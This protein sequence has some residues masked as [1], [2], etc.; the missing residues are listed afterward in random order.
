MC[1][2]SC[3]TDYEKD[4]LALP[5][6][7]HRL[8]V[9][10]LVLARSFFF[11]SLEEHASSSHFSAIYVSARFSPTTIHGILGTLT[12]LSSHCKKAI[13]Y[14]ASTHSASH[15]FQR[16]LS[17]SNQGLNSQCLGFQRLLA[18]WTDPQGSAK[19]VRARCIY[20]IFQGSIHQWK[21]SSLSVCK[22]PSVNK[23]FQLH[24][25]LNAACKMEQNRASGL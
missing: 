9:F 10:L 21:M 23:S 12:P 6:W 15:V 7:A 11:I 13:S 22:P 3:S 18:W 17:L 4:A 20:L 19:A 5:N 16:V 24:G 14:L 8:E 1:N 2:S 25:T